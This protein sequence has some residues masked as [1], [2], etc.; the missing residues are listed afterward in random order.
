MKSDP[1]VKALS[2]TVS[3]I[4]EVLEDACEQS[5]TGE[6]ARDMRLA[7][8]RAVA[9]GK[10][11]KDV[12]AEISEPLGRLDKAAWNDRFRADCVK[13]HTAVSQALD[14]S[15]LMTAPIPDATVPGRIAVDKVLR[16]VSDL[17]EDLFDPAEKIRLRE[18][19]HQ[20]EAVQATIPPLRTAADV[21]KMA[22]EAD[23]RFSEDR[24]RTESF[25]NRPC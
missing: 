22:R 8:V 1:R 13:M 6:A 4:L 7:L 3:P 17:R 23:V 9:S 14:G 10:S 20:I 21:M 24:R 11:V 25:F 15:L 16:M 2:N 12:A 19:E 5:T 18:V